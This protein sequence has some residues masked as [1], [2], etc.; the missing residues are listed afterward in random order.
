M[1]PVRR[2]LA[3]TRLAIVVFSLPDGRGSVGLLLAGVAVG[4]YCCDG[5]WAGTQWHRLSIKHHKKA[6]K[7]SG[8][9]QSPGNGP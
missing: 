6:V 3:L 9:C 7:A 8:G 4:C 2:G 1:A 5:G